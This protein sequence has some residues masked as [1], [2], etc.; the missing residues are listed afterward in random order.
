MHVEEVCGCQCYD[1]LRMNTKEGVERQLQN[2]DDAFD[3][4]VI[5]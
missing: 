1:A 3:D 5:W 2:V 4:Y